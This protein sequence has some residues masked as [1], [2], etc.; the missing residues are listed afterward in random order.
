MAG[1]DQA[2]ALLDRQRKVVGQ[3]RGFANLRFGQYWNTTINGPQNANLWTSF[4]RTVYYTGESRSKTLVY[5]DTLVDNAFSVLIDMYKFTKAYQSDEYRQAIITAAREIQLL[6]LKIQEN[7]IALKGVY[8]K[9]EDFK[10]DINNKIDQIKSRFESTQKQYP[11]DTSIIYNP[12]EPMILS[13]GVSPEKP[14]SNGIHKVTPVRVYTSKKTGKS[15]LSG[16]IVENIDE[17]P[18]SPDGQDETY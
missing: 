13:S 17:I 18:A 4:I 14:N 2:R 3:L 6:I 10:A 1:L 11:I 9:D 7:I 16:V 15:G 8:H 5:I 12:P